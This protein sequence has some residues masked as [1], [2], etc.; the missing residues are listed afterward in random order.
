MIRAMIKSRGLTY[1]LLSIAENAMC[2]RSG[3]EQDMISWEEREREKV[4]G[5]EGERGKR[6]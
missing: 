4:R 2:S 5:G 1:R 6:G 3:P